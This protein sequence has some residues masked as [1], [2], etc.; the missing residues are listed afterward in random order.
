MTTFISDAE[1]LKIGIRRLP[2]AHAGAAGIKAQ[3][4]LYA[5]TDLRD[6]R[7]IGEIELSRNHQFWDYLEK[8]PKGRKAQQVTY[9]IAALDT[10]QLL[11]Q[12]KAQYEHAEQDTEAPCVILPDGTRVP[13][14]LSREDSATPEE[15]AEAVLRA[16]LS[17]RKANATA[18]ESDR[19][20]LAKQ[21]QRENHALEIDIRFEPTGGL[22]DAVMHD[23]AYAAILNEFIT[24]PA[25]TRA[26]V[27]VLS[28]DYGD[29]A[30]QS[31]RFIRSHGHE[32]EIGEPNPA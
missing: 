8:H 22:W 20:N 13:Y 3:N 30:E 10:P 29:K 23:E 17:L 14:Y 4:V 18:V 1:K 2:A 19:V 27:V 15:V 7:R 11:E 16:L 31:V 12:L 26:P 6:G 24:D 25:Q 21:R 28:A 5:V 9:L 32:Q